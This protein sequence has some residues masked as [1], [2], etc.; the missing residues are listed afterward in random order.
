MFSTK[1]ARLFVSGGQRPNR[2]SK[3]SKHGGSSGS[4]GAEKDSGEAPGKASREGG[5]EVFCAADF[6]EV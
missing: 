5:Q 1:T 4:D 3:T 2:N 6:E